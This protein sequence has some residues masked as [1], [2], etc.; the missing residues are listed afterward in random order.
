MRKKVFGKK[1][2]RDTNERKALFKNLMRSLVLEERIKTTE[3]KAKAI[4][5]EIEKMVTYAKKKS[6][7]AQNY[8]QKYF[9]KEVYDK[10]ILDIA[11]RFAS[12]PGGYTRIIKLG[13]RL[14]DNAPLVFLEWVEGRKPV[15]A[16]VQKEKKAEKPIASAKSSM[17]SVKSKKV[18]EKDAKNNKT[19][20]IK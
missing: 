19:N 6:G 13:G 8:L 7:R 1:L 3:A 15:I 4:K 14:K 18:K 20:K 12:R 11:P 16:E 10:I 17:S 5:G 2:S 9:P